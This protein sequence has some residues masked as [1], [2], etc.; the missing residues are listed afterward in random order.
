[1]SNGATD[2][3]VYV[4]TNGSS[5]GV[6][7]FRRAAD[8]GLTLLDS[9]DTGGAGDQAPQSRRRVRWSPR[10]TAGTCWSGTRR[11]L[12]PAQVGFTPDCSALI[13]TERGTDSMRAIPVEGDADG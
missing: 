4:Q 13:V 6:M 1:M 8:G 10:R 3:A 2:G 9:S 12:T 11:S 7:A 5:H